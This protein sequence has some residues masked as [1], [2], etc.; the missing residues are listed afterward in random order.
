MP[1]SKK[2]LLSVILIV[3]SLSHLVFSQ[4]TM[5]SFSNGMKYIMVQDVEGPKSGEQYFA[6]EYVSDCLL[7][8][9]ENYYSVSMEEPH[10][11][12]SD[13]FGLKISG[14]N[15]ARDTVKRVRFYHCKTG[16]YLR[17]WGGGGIFDDCSFIENRTWAMRTGHAGSKNFVVSNCT[18]RDNKDGFA[19]KA[20]DSIW[21]HHNE[22]Y[23]DTLTALFLAGHA[24]YGK[25]LHN[26][27][28]YNRMTNHGRYG[29]EVANRADSNYIRYN[30]FIN[31]KIKIYNQS[32]SN[33]FLGNHIS[34]CDTAITIDDCVGNVFES[35]TIVD[36]D[37]HLVLK[38]NSDAIFVGTI[39]DSAK[40][41]LE[42]N[43]SQLTVKWFLDLQ[44]VDENNNPLGDVEIKIFNSNDNLVITDTTNVDGQ[45]D[46]QALTSYIKEK[47]LLISFSPFRIETDIPGYD[48]AIVDL[49]ENKAIKITPSGVVGIDKKKFLPLKFTLS[50]NYP[51]PFNPLTRISYELPGR[52]PVSLKIYDIN[53]R[54]V[55]IIVNEQ[56][57][58]GEKIAQWDG[59]DQLG[60]IVTSGIYF[61]KLEAG[62]FKHIKRMVLLK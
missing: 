62:P 14:E 12:D 4:V 48:P 37:F 21:V 46:T 20:A 35:D 29:I 47:N 32:N 22:F 28:E 13:C 60:R 7:D 41:R 38:N 45:I 58:A 54:L 42:D 5:F 10:G 57:S 49:N 51:N 27:I 61:Y 30:K 55:R 59:K 36:S 23:R 8:G 26:V 33:L 50:Q 44:F 52:L 53:G 31:D 24:D 43:E 39:F 6:M 1:I 19:L 40:V 2:L 18:F 11:T 15:A 16:V 17:G 25:S 9:S 34:D 56:Q 3:F